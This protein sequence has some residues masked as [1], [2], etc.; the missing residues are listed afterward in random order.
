M[1]KR[2][3]EE[4]DALDRYNRGFDNLIWI[5]VAIA[6]IVGA[7]QWAGQSNFID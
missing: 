6:L 4:Q 2:T 3:K 7:I 1:E 5:V